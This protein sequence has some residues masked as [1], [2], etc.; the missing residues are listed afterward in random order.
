[1][2]VWL[3]ILIIFVCLVIIGIK[4]DQ[5]VPA[6]TKLV[7]RKKLNLWYLGF[8]FFSIFISLLQL[9][10]KPEFK[11]F[12]PGAQSSDRW[13]FPVH[14]RLMFLVT[15]IFGL[16]LIFSAFFEKDKK[17]PDINSNEYNKICISC[18]NILDGNA[19]N[20][21]VCSQC[22]GAIEGIKGVIDRHPEFLDNIKGGS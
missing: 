16:L 8:G 13:G 19:K 20:M 2:Y 7:K 4:Y 9:S 14:N 10:E 6:L 22:G 1:M 12:S 15:F 18:G 11:K 21:M 3:F 17:E 5:V